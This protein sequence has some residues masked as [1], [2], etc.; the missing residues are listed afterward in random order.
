MAQ[1]LT[2]RQLECLRLSATMTDKDIGRHLGISHH[3]VSLHVR[4]AMRR[5]QVPSRKAALRLIASDPL[6][7]P[8][9]IAPRAGPVPV[10][11]APG[12][13][14]DDMEAMIGASARTWP[15]P[16]P[17]RR[18]VRL[19]LILLFAAVAALIT[20]GIVNVVF[21]AVGTLAAHA[22]PNAILTPD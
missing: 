7:G 1:R 8:D 18:S 12:D 22:P 21:G 9:A 5:L 15:L 13:P 4:E 2:D 16:P 6:Y 20:V 11:F 14:V 19:G 17:P 10:Q 3:T